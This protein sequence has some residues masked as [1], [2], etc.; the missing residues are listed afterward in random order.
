MYFY[1]PC[2][3]ER[4]LLQ[5]FDFREHRLGDGVE[6]AKKKIREFVDFLDVDRP[7]YDDHNTMKSLVK[8]GDIL[9]QVEL[10]LGNL[11]EVKI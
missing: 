11:Y 6:L 5:V 3:H 1:L 10:K 2:V 8:K 4:L 9:E 7:L